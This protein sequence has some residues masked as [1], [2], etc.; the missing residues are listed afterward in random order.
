MGRKKN[1]HLNLNSHQ[2][3][4]L[5]VAIS[6][7][8]M[9]YNKTED[10]VKQRMLRRAKDLQEIERQLVVYEGG[11]CNLSSWVFGTDNKNEPTSK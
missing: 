9:E 2:A 10:Y 7:W 5:Q 6:Y 8:K 4:A 11:V 3:F 1:L